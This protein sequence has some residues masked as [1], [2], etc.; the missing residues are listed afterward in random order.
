[1]PEHSSDLGD[2]QDDGEMPGR[3]GAH[4]RVQP[5]K[6][7]LQH[8][9]IHEQDRGQRLV[10]GGRRHLPID[11]QMAEKRLYFRRAQLRRMPLMVKE[12]ESA[13]PAEVLVLCSLAIVEGA[14]SVAHLLEEPRLCVH[15]A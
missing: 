2:R 6:L 5:R 1:M 8:M 14:Q 9:P 3:L 7:R 10:L 13:D 12:D 11:R 15:A 4:D